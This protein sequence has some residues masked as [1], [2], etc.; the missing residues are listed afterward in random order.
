VFSLEK[1]RLWGDLFVAFLYPEA[2]GTAEE[3]LF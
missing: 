1:G 3:G 2:Y